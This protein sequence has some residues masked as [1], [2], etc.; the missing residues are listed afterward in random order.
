MK[1]KYTLISNHLIWNLSH[2]G[3]T[4]VVHT[5]NQFIGRSEHLCDVTTVTQSQQRLNLLLV[6]VFPPSTSSSACHTD[7]WIG[8]H[9]RID[10]IYFKCNMHTTIPPYIHTHH[11]SEDWL[12]DDAL[13]VEMINNGDD[14][15]S[16]DFIPLHLFC[17]TRFQYGS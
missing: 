3:H 15:C 11:C 10:C 17:E 1:F 12:C 8:T 6:S 5:F 13:P 16:I 9:C 14:G 4:C 2:C 7:H